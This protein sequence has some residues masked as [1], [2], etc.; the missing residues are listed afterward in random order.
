MNAMRESLSG[1]L[2]QVSNTEIA[3]FERN[4]SKGFEGSDVARGASKIS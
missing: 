1:I 3:D 4:T 2:G